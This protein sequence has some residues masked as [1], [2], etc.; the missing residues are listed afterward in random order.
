METEYGSS[1]RKIGQ[2]FEE[3]KN[4]YSA[5]ATD[6]VNVFLKVFLN[7]Y[8]LHNLPYVFSF[9]ESPLKSKDTSSIDSLRRL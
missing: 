9:A 8:I 6:F 4:V 3:K 7:I 5:R 2:V 1:H